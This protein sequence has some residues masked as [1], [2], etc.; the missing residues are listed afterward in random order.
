MI[1]GAMIPLI[2]DSSIT[3]QGALMPDPDFPTGDVA[4]SDVFMLAIFDPAFL[5][6]L[7]TDPKQACIDQGFNLCDDDMRSLMDI[8]YSPT[9]FKD[10]GQTG[11]RF[12]SDMV[13]YATGGKPD[14]P[15]WPP[16]PP[17]RTDV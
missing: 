2:A 1:P 4:I 3:I 5:D 14:P 17:W 10:N 15:K 13:A 6:R 12:V 11:L 8:L 7:V 9:V 16:P